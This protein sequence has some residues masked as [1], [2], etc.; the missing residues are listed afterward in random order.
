MYLGGIFLLERLPTPDT[1]MLWTIVTIEVSVSP[2]SCIRGPQSP[3]INLL[4]TTL[5]RTLSLRL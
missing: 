5:R 3:G 2:P 4:R 1:D